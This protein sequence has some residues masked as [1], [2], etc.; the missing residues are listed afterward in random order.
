MF[1]TIIYIIGFVAAAIFGCVAGVVVLFM[2]MF[3]LAGM[4]SDPTSGGAYVGM[5]MMLSPVAGVIGAV[6][7]LAVAY[8]RI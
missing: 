5:A 8:S 2:I 3:I 1:A 4:N 7:A 6:V